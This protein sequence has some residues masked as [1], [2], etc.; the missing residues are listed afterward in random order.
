MSLIETCKIPDGCLS[1]VMPAFNEEK[2]IEQ[3]IATVL[4]EASVGELVVVDDASLDGT[5][6]VVKRLAA[7]DSR[8]RFFQ[9]EKN[10]GK[11]GALATGFEQVSLPIVIIQDADAEYDPAEYNKL[12]API[13]A[14]YA[15]VVFGSR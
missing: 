12:L 1:V 15:D 3:V 8:I 9:H 10:R 2:T 14:G 5:A 4:A 6:Q 13:C 11:G 7:A